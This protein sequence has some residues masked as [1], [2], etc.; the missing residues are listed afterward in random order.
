VIENQYGRADH[1]HLTRGL[2]Y[3][4]ARRPRGPRRHRREA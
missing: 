1:D 3:A 2:A 4:I